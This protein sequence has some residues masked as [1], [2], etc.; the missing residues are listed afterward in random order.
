MNEVND[1]VIH[2]IQQSWTFPAI[3]HCN[4]LW[5]TYW[6]EYNTFPNFFNLKLVV[7]LTSFTFSFWPR[8]LQSH[9]PFSSPA[10][11]RPL[12]GCRRSSHACSPTVK[13][14]WWR[15]K[16]GWKNE[17]W[18]TKTITIRTHTIEYLAPSTPSVQSRSFNKLWNLGQTSAWF[19]LAKGEKWIDQPCNN[20]YKFKSQ[21]WQFRVSIL[22]NPCIH[23]TI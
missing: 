18:K 15:L 10:S 23:V 19:C 22:T 21:L 20:F 17:K 4:A 8:S 1:W 11:R 7:F 2:I 5:L 12:R 16:I 9:L 13:R 14:L 6:L 3:H